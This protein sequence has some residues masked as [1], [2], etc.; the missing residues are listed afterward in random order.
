MEKLNKKPLKKIPFS[1]CKTGHFYVANEDI[2]NLLQY[3]YNIVQQL[4]T[5]GEKSYR[6]SFVW[7]GGRVAEGNG[8]LNRHT[9]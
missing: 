4:L 9:G 8:L 1:V 3:F 7:R 6:L 2:I 5:T